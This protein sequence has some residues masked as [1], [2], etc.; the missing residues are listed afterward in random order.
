MSKA[1][2][3]NDKP[4]ILASEDL[5]FGKS[6]VIKFQSGPFS[7][8]PSTLTAPFEKSFHVDSIELCATRC[9][10][11][12]CSSAKYEPET[13]S[14]LLAYEDKPV[15][16]RSELRLRVKEVTGDMWIHCVNC[17]PEK[18]VVADVLSG[19][20]TSEEEKEEEKN[21]SML[22]KVVGAVS[23]VAHTVA[24]KVSGEK[25]DTVLKHG[26][27]VNFQT[28]PFSEMAEKIE[29]LP[30]FKTRYAHR[31]ATKCFQEGCAAATFNPSTNDCSLGYG[32]F[33]KCINSPLV[34]TALELK[35]TV[36]I[37]CIS[38]I[39]H[40]PGEGGI[41]LVVLSPDD[42]RIHVSESQDVPA[43][44]AEGSGTEEATVSSA[45][46]EEGS[47]VSGAKEETTVSGA[48]EG[49]TV[50]GTEEVTTESGTEEG[51][52]V[53]GAEEETTVSGAEEGTTVSGTEEVTTESGTEEG[54]TVSGA[55]VSGE[56]NGGTLGEEGSGSF[57]GPGTG[58]ISEVPL[59]TG[60]DGVKIP[61]GVSEEVG[62]EEGRVEVNGEKGEGKF[63]PSLPSGFSID[64][65]LGRAQVDGKIDENEGEKTTGT[66]EKEVT[67][68]GETPPE[69]TA[70]AATEGTGVG[71]EPGAGESTTATPPESSTAAEESEF[72]TGATKGE[73]EGEATTASTEESASTETPSESTTAASETSTT[74]EEVSSTEGRSTEGTIHPAKEFEHT[75]LH[76]EGEEVEVESAEA[77]TGKQ[78]EGVTSPSKEAEATTAGEKATTEEEGPAFVQE[79]PSEDE[80]KEEG[81]AI[82]DDLK[83]REGILEKTL[84]NA[85]PKKPIESGESTTGATVSAEKPSAAESID[86]PP[87]TGSP[88]EE[89]EAGKGTVTP[90]ESTT[91]TTPAVTES[92]GESKVE[93]T[94]AAEETGVGEIDAMAAMDAEAALT[95]TTSPSGEGETSTTTTSEG[96]TSEESTTSA[97]E[98]QH[99]EGILEKALAAAHPSAT[100]KEGEK[101]E[102]T[103]VAAETGEESSTST[104]EPTLESTVAASTE[105]AATEGAETT[106]ASS[107]EGA[108]TTVASSTEGGETTVASEGSSTVAPIGGMAASVDEKTKEEPKA[109]EEEMTEKGEVKEIGSEA[110]LEG[111]STSTPS[112]SSSTSSPLSTTTVPSPA[113][114]AAIVHHEKGGA[115]FGQAE[116]KGAEKVLE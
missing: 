37:H 92:E 4:L 58:K 19:N 107:T 95:T 12:G 21:K 34:T 29:F 70:A 80:E 69:K 20:K 35:E 44:E 53:S 16:D 57:E 79:S 17:Y 3:E 32:K 6:C 99:R 36:T 45:G 22:D 14:C 63:K 73:E 98:L 112:E 27:I 100:T 39:H 1:I 18:M 88:I 110:S 101:S 52:T 15:C 94:T 38:C 33:V 89:E 78:E 50:S 75:P 25:A 81:L 55:E 116:H 83:H 46:T 8:R 59:E 13:S 84:A 49:T 114:L 30:P 10:Q 93:G 65:G 60:A 91:G 106:V 72:S 74:G 67:G 56:V 86:S 66:G 42:A 24:E 28:S 68:E 48:E 90:V 87:T 77:T 51:S 9:F 103:T 96:T 11:D 62:E 85:S 47:T 26:C 2:E 54:S 43:E 5:N 82:S 108:D 31:C 102:T 97:G 76:P 105:A 71:S 23:G 104:S 113:D 41:D 7:D 64:S 109:V 40:K 61:A 115:E 111:T